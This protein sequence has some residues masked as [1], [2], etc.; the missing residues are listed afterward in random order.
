MYRLH[1]GDSRKMPP[2]SHGHKGK[3]GATL[4]YK[5]WLGIKRRCFKENC[6]DYPKWG[7]QGIT[8][9]DA[10]NNSFEQFLVDMGPRPSAR[11]QID[12][13]DPSGNYEPDNCRWVTPTEQGS[14]NRRNLIP[15]V[16]DGV[17]FKS[18]SAACRHF[19]VNKTAASYRIRAG[20]PAEIAVK[21]EPWAMKARRTRESYLP[22]SH[23]DRS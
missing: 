16:V 3:N 4:E 22:K 6:K 21:G 18:M 8:V 17:E 19:G 15:V 5:T 9:C 13:I 23:P 20:I 11:H 12:R 14:E 10:W 1:P 7:G 2:R